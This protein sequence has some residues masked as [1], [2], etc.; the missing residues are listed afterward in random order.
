MLRENKL[1]KSDGDLG[2]KAIN[3]G[4]YSCMHGVG[5]IVCLCSVDGDVRYINTCT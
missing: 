2:V 1:N 4:A 5:E 3:W